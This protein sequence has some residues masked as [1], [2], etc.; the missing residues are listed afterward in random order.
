MD[1]PTFR[2]LLT[3]AGQAALL[4]AA[5]LGPT[6]AG[7]LAAFEAVRKRHPPALA[8][9]AV[10]TVLL[11]R[12]ASAKF[13]AADRMYFTREALE[14]ASGGAVA[15]YR[16]GRLA[17]YPVVLD[18]GCG[19]G[20]DALALAAA[21]CRVEAIDRDELRLA[22]A[23]ANAAALGLADRVRVTRGDVLAMPLPPADAAVADPSRRAG[24]RR[25]LAPDRY[26]PPLGAVLGRF[27]VGFPLAAKIAPGVA[28][29]DIEGYDAEAEWITAGGE[30][31]ECVLW[32]GPLKTAGRRATVIGPPPPAGE[33]SCIPS[34]AADRPVPDPPAGPIG[35]Y[36]FDPDPA[37]IRADL[38][39]LLA[40]RLGAVAVD[41]GVAVL[42]APAGVASPFADTYRV[43]HAAPVH[44]G[45]LRD[46]LRERRVGRVTVLK[47]AAE[48]DA[49]GLVKKLKLGGPD[50]RHLI[51]TRSGGR[52][53][54]VVGE[55]L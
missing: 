46:Y 18:L 50:H 7:F 8:K 49:D 34:L 40:G 1:L 35:E 26:D 9:A 2:D 5:A 20:A 22:M 15:A 51:L 11:R 54:A 3:P 6:E 37:V 41:P 43:E 25:F 55:K 38:V 28:R 33:G 32:F 31:K 45:R 21:G 44:P 42:T 53:V 12:R 30:L 27:P 52:A 29:R 39:G 48:V 19:V 13:A 14:Q 23:G 16:A 10:E 24:D 36:L 4:A 17:A 47:R